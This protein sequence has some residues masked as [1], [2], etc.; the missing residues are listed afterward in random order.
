MSAITLRFAMTLPKQG[1]VERVLAGDLGALARLA[2]HIENDTPVGRVGLRKLYPHT[3]NAHIVGMTG[4]PGAGKSTIV[5]AL[6]H[7]FRRQGKRV[8]IVAVDP[9]SPLSGGAALGDRIR[10]LDRWD[11]ADVFI[12]SMASR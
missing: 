9:S 3:G 8:A 4:A 2:S 7:A 11:D 10:M 1:L 5:N 6:I 12:R